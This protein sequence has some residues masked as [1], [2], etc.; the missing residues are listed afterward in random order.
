[1]GAAGKCAAGWE[2]RGYGTLRSNSGCRTRRNRRR[3]PNASMAYWGTMRKTWWLAV[4]AAV[5][6]ALGGC[7][8]PD[9]SKKAAPK[10]AKVEEK[11]PELFQVVF[12]TSRGK[13]VVEVHRDW[14]P[15]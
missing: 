8:S 11:T 7:S 9:E 10:A 6:L 14:A 12:D 1:G 15:V 3:E 4:G 5:S 2:R 13:V